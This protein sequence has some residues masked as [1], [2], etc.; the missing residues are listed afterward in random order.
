MSTILS[1]KRERF[2]YRFS[3]VHDKLSR[4][5]DPD[6]LSRQSDPD[7]PSRQPDPD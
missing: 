5:S 2:L 6:K 4:Q 1:I 3:A 7:K